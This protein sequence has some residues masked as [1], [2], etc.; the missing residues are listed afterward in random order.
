VAIQFNSFSSQTILNN[1]TKL[2]TQLVLSNERL[3]TA[4]RVNRAA[5]DPSGVVALSQFRSEIA[6]IDAAT[7]NG[8]RIVNMLDTADGGLSEISDLLDTIDTAVI[9][10]SDTGATAEEKAAYQ[11]EIDAAINAVNTIVNETTFNNKRLLDGTLGYVNSSVT[12]TDLQDLRVNSADTS[13]GS[14]SVSVN[15]TAIAQKATLTY[16]GG[17]L[18]ANTDVTLAGNLGT[19]DFSFTAGTNVATMASTIEAQKDT[20]GVSAVNSG[21]NLVLT[22]LE[23]GEDEFIS[24]DVTL[25]SLPFTSGTTSDYGVDPTVLVNGV[26]APADGLLVNASSNSLTMR[27]TLTEAFATATGSTT[28]DIDAGGAQFQLNA[29]ASTRIDVGVSS[30]SAAHLGNDTVGRLNTLKTG[31]TNSIDSGNFNQA[32]LIVSAGSSLVS[33]ERGRLG[34]ISNYSVTST[35][36][37]MAESKTQITSAISNIEDLDIAQETANNVQLQAMLDVN[38]ALLG[39]INNNTTTILSL[40]SGI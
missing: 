26:A 24:A 22:S 15:V 17:A 3:A 18:A 10:A 33:Y 2:S 8:Q 32:R 28:F 31:G 29:K 21:G 30:L 37:A 27:F 11:L 5:D 36:N 16:A 13:S 40:I 34:A 4:K 9:A 1:L 19:Y 25:G 6:S 14:Q 39:A 12:T 35:L 23:Y 20:T 7:T 38:T